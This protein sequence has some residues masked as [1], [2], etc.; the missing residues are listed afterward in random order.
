VRDVSP[1]EI[2]QNY[3]RIKEEIRMV[4]NEKLAGTP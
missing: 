2:Q 4:V 1:E 3:L